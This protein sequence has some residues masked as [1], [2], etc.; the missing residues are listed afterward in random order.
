MKK[1]KEK[2]I[3]KLIDIGKRSRKLIAPILVAVTMLLVAYYSVREFCIQMR[4]P[5]FRKRFICFIMMLV[6]FFTQ[7]GVS[8]VLAAGISGIAESQTLSESE[9][10]IT[11][12]AEITDESEKSDVSDASEESAGSD[13][14]AGDELSI[15]GFKPLAEEIEEQKVLPGTAIEKLVLPEELTVYVSAMQGEPSSTPAGEPT[16]SPTSSPSSTPTSTPTGEPGSTPT[17]EPSSTP[18]GEPGSTPTGSPASTPTGE[19]VSTPTSTPAGESGNTPTEEPGG[20]PTEKPADE[21][22]QEPVDEPT[23]EPVDEPTQE[24]VDEP[25]DE[26]ADVPAGESDNAPAEET[27]NNSTEETNINPV[28]EQVQDSFDMPVN[29]GRISVR[30]IKLL[31]KE[32]TLQPE[33]ATSENEPSETAPKNEQEE[34]QPGEAAPENEQE[35]AQPGETVPENEQEETQ[36]GEDA[37][38]NEQEAP[39]SGETTPETEQEASQPEETVLSGVTWICE[40]EYR[41][42]KLGIYVFTPELPENCVLDEGAELPTITVTVE[43]SVD[44]GQLTNLNQYFEERMEDLLEE[45]AEEELEELIA[46]VLSDFDVEKAEEGVLLTA[47]VPDQRGRE[48]LEYGFVWSEDEGREPTISD[49]DGMAAFV[50]TEGLGDFSYTIEDLEDANARAYLIFDGWVYYST[51]MTTVNLVE[52]GVL[53]PMCYSARGMSLTSSGED[54]E[55]LVYGTGGAFDLAWIGIPLSILPVYCGYYLDI[56]RKIDP[57][58]TIYVAIK[59]SI[60]G[61]PILDINGKHIGELQSTAN[62]EYYIIAMK[63][64]DLNEGRNFINIVLAPFVGGWFYVDNIQFI[65]GGGP[66]NIGGST[67]RVDDVTFQDYNFTKKFATYALTVD[68]LLKT[69][70][71][72]GSDQRVITSVTVDGN[73]MYASQKYYTAEQGAEVTLSTVNKCNDGILTI[74]RGTLTL[75]AAMTAKPPAGSE[76]A[77][78]EPDEVIISCQADTIEY[79]DNEGPNEFRLDFT[80]DQSY[81]R[82]R[83][84]DGSARPL[85]IK[86]KAESVF[87]EPVSYIVLP[88]ADNIP[89]NSHE[90]DPSE[91]GV[92]Y[93][94]QL[95]NSGNMAKADNAKRVYAYEADFSVTTNGRYEFKVVGPTT[96]ET[97]Y[98]D[99]TN[100][101]NEKPNVEVVGSDQLTILEDTP[102][103]DMGFG[104]QDNR[105]AE[106]RITFTT[107]MGGLNAE[108]PDGGDYTVTYK[109][110]DQAGNT[111]LLTRHIQVANRPLKLA[112]GDVKKSGSTV[113]MSGNIVYLGDDTIVE[114][115]LVWDVSSTPTIASNLGISTA[116]YDV[117]NKSTF[118]ANTSLSALIPNATYYCRSYAK[119]AGGKVV[120][121]PAVSFEASDKNY[122]SFYISDISPDITPSSSKTQTLTVTVKRKGGTD[123]RQTVYWRTVDGSAIAGTHYSSAGGSVT[124]EDGQSSKTVK[125]TVKKNPTS[126][127]CW[128]VSP[129]VFFVELYSVSGGGNLDREK[130]TA[131]V[132]LNTTDNIQRTNMNQWVTIVSNE[133]GSYKKFGGAAFGKRSYWYFPSESGYSLAKYKYWAQHGRVQGKASLIIDMKSSDSG[134]YV[135]VRQG[136]GGWVERAGHWYDVGDGQRIAQTGVLDLTGQDYVMGKGLSQVRV[137][138]SWVKMKNPM[139]SVNY[140]DTDNPVIQDIC[141]L[142][143][144]YRADD[145]IYFTVRFNEIVLVDNQKSL[146]L[147]IGMDGGKSGTATY[148]SGSGTDVLV[149]KMTAP[150]STES[151]KVTATVKGAG[152]GNVHDFSGKGVSDGYSKELNV[153]ISSMPYKITVNPGSGA[154]ARAHKVTINVEK[155]SNYDGKNASYSY[156][157]S[158]SQNFGDVTGQMK[159]F[160]SGDTV[161]LDGGTGNFW[162]HIMVKDSKGAY[163]AMYGPY[164]ISNGLPVFEPSAPTAWTNADKVKVSLKMEDES[165]IND[166]EV[167]KNL[168]IS[169]KENIKKEDGTTQSQTVTI[170]LKIENGSFYFEVTENGDY[171][172]TATDRYS[173]NTHTASLSVSCFDRKNPT[174]KLAADLTSG[175]QFDA[176]CVKMEWEEDGKPVSYSYTGK[177]PAVYLFVT[178]DASGLKSLQYA[179]TKSSTAPADGAADWLSS[180]DEAFSDG[181][182]IS[183]AEYLAA[184]RI[185]G[186]NAYGEF[187]LHLLTKDQAGN[188]KSFTHG[189][190]FV[191]PEKG[192]PPVV[193]VEVQPLKGGFNDFGTEEPAFSAADLT[194]RAPKRFTARNVTLH[195]TVKA[196]KNVA[197]ETR[198]L[199]GTYLPETSILYD[200][201]LKDGG[202]APAVYIDGR[203]V[204]DTNPAEGIVEFDYPVSKNGLYRFM[205]T[206]KDGTSSEYNNENAK[207]I[208]TAI[209]KDAPELTYQKL[210]GAGSVLLP[211]DWVGEKEGVTLKLSFDDM[212]SPIYGEGDAFLGYVGSGVSAYQITEG[213]GPEETV[214]TDYHGG[215][216][217]FKVNKNSTFFVKVK[218]KVGNTYTQNITVGN[219]DTTPP[220]VD[221]TN[222]GFGVG[223]APIEMQLKFSDKEMGLVKV[224]K[225]AILPTT[226]LPA[227]QKPEEIFEDYEGQTISLKEAGTYYIHYIAQDDV[228]GREKESLW[229]PQE[230]QSHT[231]RGYFGPYIIDS[232]KPAI[233]IDSI[234]SDQCEERD[235]K[236]VFTYRDDKYAPVHSAQVTIEYPANMDQAKVEGAKRQYQWSQSADSPSLFG[237]KDLSTT[238]QASL[239]IKKDDSGR[240]VATFNIDE[241]GKGNTNGRWYLHVRTQGAGLLGSYTSAY[242]GFLF[243]NDLPVITV[244]GDNPLY[245]PRGESYIDRGARASDPQGQPVTVTTKTTVTDEDGQEKTVDTRYIDID[246]PGEH[247]VLYTATDSS[248]NSAT[249]T[250]I[251]Y[252]YDNVQPAISDF[253]KTTKEDTTLS[254]T[255]EDFTDCYWDD[256]N[257]PVMDDKGNITQNCSLSKIVITRLPGHGNLRLNGALVRER[258]EIPADMLGSL[259][260]DPVLDYYN[261][262][263]AGNKLGEDSFAW[264][265]YD[266]GVGE[267]PSNESRKEAKVS[268][269]VE[270]VN[271]PPTSADASFVTE[272]EKQAVIDLRKVLNGDTAVTDVEDGI[273][274]DT[275]LTIEIMSGVNFAPA[276]TTKETDTEDSISIKNKAGG[277]VTVND[278]LTLIYTPAKDF[279]GT[280]TIPYRIKDTGNE[281]SAQS[282]LTIF[283]E[284]VN[285]KPVFADTASVTFTEDKATTDNLFMGE[286]KI[287]FNWDAAQD[288]DNDVPTYTVALKDVKDHE[289]EPEV[290]STKIEGT[291]YEWTV[292]KE[293]T[294]G[295][296]TVLVTPSDALEDGEPIETASF[297]VDN[298]PPQVPELIQSSPDR[299]TWAFYNNKD[300]GVQASV[301]D[302]DCGQ[303]E[304]NTGNKLTL[305]YTVEESGD[306]KKF[307]AKDWKDIETAPADGDGWREISAADLLTV[308]TTEGVNKLRLQVTDQAGNITE[309]T[310]EDKYHLDKTAPRVFTPAFTLEKVETEEGKEAEAVTSLTVQADTEDTATDKLTSV[311]ELMS[312]PYSYRIEEGNKEAD[313]DKKTNFVNVVTSGGY[314]SN[315]YDFSSEGFVEP[316]SSGKFTFKTLTWPDGHVDGKLKPNTQYTVTVRTV[317]KAGN[318]RDV[319][320]A[321][322]T[323]AQDAQTATLTEWN[324]DSLTITFT[325]GA[326]PA[327]T[328][329][330]A[331]LTKRFDNKE[332]W[333]SKI[334][335]TSING[336]EY[337]ENENK[338][339][340]FENLEEDTEYTLHIQSMNGDEVA[341]EEV[342]FKKDTTGEKFKTNKKVVLTLNDQKIYQYYSEVDGSGAAEPGVILRDRHTI[343]FSGTVKDPDVEYH[344]MTDKPKVTVTFLDET[345][346]RYITR[347]AEDADV[348]PASSLLTRLADAV[349]GTQ[350]WEWS[351]TF[352]VDETTGTSELF[353]EENVPDGKYV[354]MVTAVDNRED[355][356]SLS[357][358]G[359]WVDRQKPGTPVITV[360]PLVEDAA[361]SNRKFSNAPQVGIT[362]TDD[363]DPAEAGKSPSGTKILRYKLTGTK[364]GLADGEAAVDSGETTEGYLTLAE[365]AE[366]GKIAQSLTGE[367]AVTAEGHTQ[368]TVQTED[369]AGNVTQ[370]DIVDIY[371]DRTQPWQEPVKAELGSAG[372]G[373]VYDGSW[374]NESIFVTITARDNIGVG[375]IMRLSRT[376]PSIRAII[377]RETL[378]R[379]IFHGSWRG[380]TL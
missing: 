96:T 307:T 361:T 143:G 206:D 215:D 44:Y 36:P 327:A 114:R 232:G 19:P 31:Q 181:G 225:F 25:T 169:V 60:V 171:E 33:A 53:Q 289:K 156:A 229:T 27:N 120:Y 315:R 332:I 151:S 174:A 139:I 244:I 4:K 94:G 377:S 216:I 346:N 270:A 20:T 357:Y 269:Y 98:L 183:L 37:P 118:T 182:R 200:N 260:Y 261:V 117:H 130:N 293:L 190:P 16:S 328:K 149:F 159:P 356:T 87:G 314:D 122:G 109:A 85:Q 351:I 354:P 95:K 65:F 205:A 78:Q 164:E 258:D 69:T 116:K 10:E 226:T 365:A 255:W 369:F 298:T 131:T 318:Y 52:D 157:F 271:D 310:I 72:T 76:W 30:E 243:D 330:R 177:D 29:M 147:D 32:D 336:E 99:V 142:S 212:V 349:S 63:G 277:N 316:N 340:T 341:N 301:S 204:K 370:A 57:N 236:L 275:G 230:G 187:Y 51:A 331:W 155:P 199:G 241:F 17:G 92:D 237:W 189:T 35:E 248:G 309:T 339:F 163:R 335:D 213:D 319:A 132:S 176:D 217:T 208:I 312:T 334:G 292:P 124:F 46:P 58:E 210:D 84:E 83:N 254:F 376:V 231:T 235:G 161:T 81:Y 234:T 150:E 50:E 267:R 290:L 56:N 80:Y 329:Y 54:A 128:E 141:A 64:R 112:T 133:P 238:E 320:K 250:R 153:H 115:G 91:E 191:I 321:L 303:K 49:N 158:T 104:G 121:G 224:R 367:I 179:F 21:P 89:A 378:R 264:L 323:R 24:P 246:V 342:F 256:S 284:N 108:H 125:V 42:T 154:N 344:G 325:A 358:D 353:T 280:V 240:C 196:G 62:E 59:G 373:R 305:K 299:N 368:L 5:Q 9:N 186:Q 180:N 214:W 197:G 297:V 220:F 126:G 222:T 363:G 251:V 274:K 281:S 324:S 198:L 194:T 103:V 38:Q 228:G 97:F 263:S 13:Q 265:A 113:S 106:D 173:G 145:S 207:A 352:T 148:V 288:A 338:T 294:S 322:Y 144:T 88:G 127:R 11:D 22:T 272:E 70:N 6:M 348:V 73:K 146:Y 12:E 326:N 302:E 48:V 75:A 67:A 304:V 82:T 138:W 2:I 137:I 345:G 160:Q 372:S 233:T 101:D 18:T 242:R 259:T 168:T 90:N 28:E 239:K 249:A 201:N 40:P 39:Q 192:E 375:A 170:P 223:K 93:A 266:T 296:Y 203:L 295:V 308:I 313:R 359:I 100:I 55:T 273:E 227:D 347:Q 379:S 360:D 247:A 374:V 172:I 165:Y 283:V 257:Q 362:L 79:K 166:E 61:V 218:D 105:S 123:G 184:R 286:Q 193:S 282:V 337:L 285:D 364:A 291:S 135:Y 333:A 66:G 252:V 86:A 68:G 245:L 306:G 195:V 219:I 202:E 317:D 175:R 74:N 278:G 188:V 34:V 23:Q 110:T 77:A 136:N 380:V 287:T 15:V 253:A 211:N 221:T 1:L 47:G 152:G 276:E 209:D 107:D 140:T 343:I 43:G 366:P 262:D 41:A 371:I 162:L 8:R 355:E 7:T 129:R 111:A 3:R 300:L 178:D 102:Y 311:S 268:L 119:T 167:R 26:P 71:M 14:E 279:N 185:T 45:P 134:L 350:T